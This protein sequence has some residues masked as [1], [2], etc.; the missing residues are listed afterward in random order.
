[1]T[2]RENEDKEIQKLHQQCIRKSRCTIDKN[3]EE[4]ILNLSDHYYYPSFKYYLEIDL[5]N[6]PFS[7]TLSAR[8]CGEN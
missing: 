3:S 2:I 5:R 7:S 1:M 6:M 4:K 8:Y